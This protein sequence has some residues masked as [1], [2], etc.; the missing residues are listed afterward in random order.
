MKI[1]FDTGITSELIEDLK[2]EKYDS[3][4][5]SEA[6]DP[7]IEQVPIIQEPLVLIVPEEGARG[8]FYCPI[9]DIAG[10]SASLCGKAIKTWERP[11]DSRG[12]WSVRGDLPHSIWETYN[13]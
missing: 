10:R 11:E 8:G 7:E 12:F 9:P 2:R 6:R 1:S 5:C 3:I 13:R 4:L